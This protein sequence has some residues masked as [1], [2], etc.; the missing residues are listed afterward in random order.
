MGNRTRG[1]GKTRRIHYSLYSMHFSK[2]K[3]DAV[4]RPLY[5]PSRSILVAV[6]VTLLHLRISGIPFTVQCS[7]FSVRAFLFLA[8]RL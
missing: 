5:T 6:L 7:V 3:H 2:E 4:H 1:P 8:R